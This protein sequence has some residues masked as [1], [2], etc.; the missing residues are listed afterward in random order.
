ML[1]I[2]LIMLLGIFTGS[3]FAASTAQARIVFMS[4]EIMKRA[5]NRINKHE[6]ALAVYKGMKASADRWMEN[7]IPLPEGPT[8]WYH[9]Y[10]CPEHGVQLRYNYN[11]P[12]E[13]VCP[14]DGKVW[15]GDKYDEYW[16]TVTHNNIANSAVN[17]AMVYGFEG[18]EEYARAAGDILLEYADFYGPHIAN[19]DKKRIMWQSLDE[20]TFILKPVQTYE[21]IYDSGVLSDEE[22]RHIEDDWLR[23]TALFLKSE[24]R[25]IHNI[26]CWYNAA[27]ISIGL[28]LDDQ[29]LVDFA[30][31]GPKGGFQEQISEGVKEDGLWYEGSFGYH[32]YTLIAL[33][34][35]II[36][37]LNNNIDISSELK[38]IKRMFKTP[39]LMANESF[40]VPPTNDSGR[41]NVMNYV[42]LY[43]IA[44]GIF[45]E[46]ENFAP[47]VAYT[48]DNTGR[49]RAR[50]EA[51]FYG[52]EELPPGKRIKVESTNF[53]G[54]GL[55]VLRNYVGEYEN[56]IMFKYGPHGGGHGHPDKMN[57][58]LSGL[59]Q[60][61]A[62][63]TGTAG[64]GLE[65]NRTWYR[66]TLSHST[67]VIDKEPQKPTEGEL[68]DFNPEGKAQ[69]VS[70]KAGEAYPGVD[71]QR[72]VF[73]DEEG[74]IVVIDVL[75]SPNEH[76]YDWVYHNYGELEVT[77]LDMQ[78]C[79]RK[80]FGESTA[81]Q[82]P[83]NLLTA[84]TDNDVKG[85]WKLDSQKKGHLHVT[86][87]P[88]TKVFSA[89]GP[90]NPA[91]ID[92]PMIVVRR[93][94]KDMVFLAVLEP[95]DG[96]AK[97][98]SISRK[99]SAVTVKSVDGKSRKFAVVN[100]NP[101][102]EDL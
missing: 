87:S 11:K 71:W 96:Q 36:P 102:V 13:H 50:S 63:D 33:K 41:G 72:S 99:D 7:K 16:R 27:I 85:I 31:S 91:K 90:G 62:P 29:E 55:A 97:I 40:E 54:V 17:L 38:V 59:G 56:Y 69:W 32:F 86:G 20:A 68:I 39:L 10:F 53:S 76:T 1:R 2:F 58:I 93:K 80:E 3:L 95:V 35:F 34:N 26:H 6:W 64:Y 101:E 61:L 94:G 47:F 77:D 42:S 100:G 52:L 19:K 81:Y 65:V 45:P 67:I 43:E 25:V 44:A 78:T 5:K 46:E 84:D 60:M 51:L 37:A 23:P 18:K 75:K 28:M 21:L 30:V 57:I 89:V 92:V 9:N 88:E 22:K 12:H 79:D 48:Y 15:T 66:Q 74:Y 14:E 98:E 83:K 24:R 73:L 8:G 70:A 4:P 49:H 82:V